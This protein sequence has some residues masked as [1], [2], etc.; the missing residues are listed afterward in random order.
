MAFVC[1]LLNA[2]HLNHHTPTTT[3]WFNYYSGRIRK[4]CIMY[5]SNH[6]SLFSASISFYAVRENICLI[7]STTI[8]QSIEIEQ[9]TKR[10]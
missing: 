8:Q 1:D 4:L 5:A 9:Q 3:T 6:T 10:K 7:L 2:I